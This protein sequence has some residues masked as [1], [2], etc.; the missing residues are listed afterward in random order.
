MPTLII[1]QI[2]LGRD[3]HDIDTTTSFVRS[4]ARGFTS[5]Y[6]PGYDLPP[7]APPPMSPIGS[8]MPPALAYSLTNQRLNGLVEM[9]S[10][11]NENEA[12]GVS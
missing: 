4:D 3:A 2:G 8:P 5:M 1:V 12:C 9:N 7:G 10:R 6:D 11:T